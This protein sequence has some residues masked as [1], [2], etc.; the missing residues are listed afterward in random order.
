MFCRYMML[1]KGE[2]HECKKLIKLK[3]DQL[4]DDLK[5]L[6]EQGRRPVD[7]TFAGAGNNR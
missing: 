3:E 5:L 4:N 7:G 6:L 2:S 1:R